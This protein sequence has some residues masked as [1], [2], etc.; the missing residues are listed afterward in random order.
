MRISENFWKFSSFSFGCLKSWSRVAQLFLVIAAKKLTRNLGLAAEFLVLGRRSHRNLWGTMFHEISPHTKFGSFS[1]I[2][3]WSTVLSLKWTHRK[4]ALFLGFATL[5]WKS[6]LAE[7]KKAQVFA[8]A[9]IP[10]KDEDK[11]SEFF[12]IVR[13]VTKFHLISTVVHAINAVVFC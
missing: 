11:E 9:Y 6:F 2:S 5:P 4:C 13:I 7:A 12:E 8:L 3:D 10:Q 1:T